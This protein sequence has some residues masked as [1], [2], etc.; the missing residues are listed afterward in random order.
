LP[1]SVYDELLAEATAERLPMTHY[2]YQLVVKR[3]LKLVEVL[4]PAAKADLSRIPKLEA[5][6]ANS[7][8]DYATRRSKYDDLAKDMAVV[9]ADRAE[10]TAK[11]KAHEHRAALLGQ[12]LAYL[13]EKF[14]TPR[15][16]SCPECSLEFEVDLRD[17]VLK[18]PAEKTIGKK[19]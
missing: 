2:C 17:E 15:R 1:V 3:P 6:L 18:H 10:L 8:A 16:I 9:K 12:D 14:T 19:G 13:N 5:A 11:V 4:P 7:R